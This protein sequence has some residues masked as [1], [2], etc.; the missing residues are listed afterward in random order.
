MRRPELPIRAMPSFAW[1]MREFDRQWI[2]N[3]HDLGPRRQWAWAEHALGCGCRER[4]RVQYD[5]HGNLTPR[6]VLE[7][8]LAAMAHWYVCRG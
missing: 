6:G 7:V 8:E 4:I 2:V 1:W 5:K 3:P